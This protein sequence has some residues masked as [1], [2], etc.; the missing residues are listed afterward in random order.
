MITFN[1]LHVQINHILLTCMTVS[2]HKEEVW[3]YK[4]SL[5][6]PL[7]SL[8][9]LYQSRKVSAHVFVVSNLP[10][11]TIL[12]F[13]FGIV[14]TVLFLFLFYILLA[15][16]WG[17]GSQRLQC[18]VGMGVTEVTM[19][20]GIVQLRNYLSFVS[21]FSEL[22]WNGNEIHINY[23]SCNI[24]YCMVLFIILYA[25]DTAIISDTT[26]DLQSD[27]QYYCYTLYVSCDK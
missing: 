13:N 22:E 10:L 4:S 15:Y 26:A 14:P 6:P 24:E 1:A 23:K 7:L 3:A 5:T 12:I 18:D 11:S 2:F 17:W 16:R 25:A 8:K 27:I 19:W 9:C 21:F 20:R